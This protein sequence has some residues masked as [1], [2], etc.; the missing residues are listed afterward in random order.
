M[1]VEEFILF[2]ITRGNDGL[3]RFSVHMRTRPS[4]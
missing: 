4:R 3:N 2:V 1:F